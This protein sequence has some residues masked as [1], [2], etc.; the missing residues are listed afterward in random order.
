[1]EFNT[2]PYIGI[3]YHNLYKIQGNRLTLG[4]LSY[5]HGPI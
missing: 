5:D 1:M 2:A 4:E 3:N